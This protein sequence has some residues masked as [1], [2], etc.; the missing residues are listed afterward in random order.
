[1]TDI[2]PKSVNFSSQINSRD[3]YKGTSFRYSGVWEAGKLYSND[4]YFVDY[5]SYNG[6][7]WVCLKSHYASNPPQQNEYWQCVVEKGD[8]GYPAIH[9]GPNP[10]TPEEYGPNYLNVLWIDS[11]EES[12][13]PKVYSA[14]EIDEILD[15]MLKEL[16]SKFVMK[17]VVD[18]MFVNGGNIDGSKWT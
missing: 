10:P 8:A 7:L 14:N 11:D 15:A 9:V 3:Y 12:S 17:D 13:S 4:T 6:S 1:M 16:H 2:K 18:S 5:V